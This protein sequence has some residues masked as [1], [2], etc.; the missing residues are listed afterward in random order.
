MGLNVGY[1]VGAAVGAETARTHAL[2]PRAGLLRRPSGQSLH[3]CASATAAYCPL[4]HAK[5]T[6]LGVL[7]PASSVA[8]PR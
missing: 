7:S 3:C 4:S 5:Q 2:A 8:I 1:R 6:V